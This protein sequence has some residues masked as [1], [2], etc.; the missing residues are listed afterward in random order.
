MRS[1]ILTTASSLP[2]KQLTVYLVN[3][4]RSTSLNIIL[5]IKISWDNMAKV[6]VC[7]YILYTLSINTEIWP[8]GLMPIALTLCKKNNDWI[9]PN[10][11]ATIFCLVLATTSCIIFDLY[12]KIKIDTFTFSRLSDCQQRKW[13]GLLSSCR[14][15]GYKYLSS[16]WPTHNDWLVCCCY[17]C[18]G[19]ANAID[20][21][22]TVH[23]DQLTCINSQMTTTCRAPCA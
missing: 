9:I 2:K 7:I 20:R 5:I 18:S 10:F 3:Q 4:S 11:D 21:P 14:W 22:P 19:W 17:G 12:S 23:V 16:V 8:C 13:A 1:L 15:G 6:N